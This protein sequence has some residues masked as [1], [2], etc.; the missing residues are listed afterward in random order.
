MV[1][2]NDD[3]LN[4][5]E[6]ES[7]LKAA[8]GE[9]A[10]SSPKSASNTGKDDSDLLSASEIDALLKNND[11]HKQPSTTTA[12]QGTDH[13]AS[14]KN[15][16]LRSMQSAAQL[17]DQAEADL[18]A[19]LSTDRARPKK[20]ISDTGKTVPFSFE[21]FGATPL[22]GDG[23][24]SLGGLQDVELDLRI[25]LGRTELLI[26]E[27]LKLKEGSVVP[28]DKLAGDPVDILVNGRLIAR[29]EVLVLNDNFCVRIAEILTPDF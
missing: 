27:V 24:L 9:S 26:E 15:D 13:T 17:I 20:V 14:T 23:L 10:T 3:L 8:R 5:D 11:L 21:E 4:P 22:A 2:D 29:G 19:A 28:L 6:I 25:E 18:S 16:A 1:Q 12:K 7:L